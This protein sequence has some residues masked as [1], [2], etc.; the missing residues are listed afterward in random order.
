MATVPFT[1]TAV[2]GDYVPLSQDLTF[3]PGVSNQSVDVT[4]NAGP[5]SEADEFFAL[6]PVSSSLNAKI[7]DAFAAGNISAG[8]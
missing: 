8:A 2:D 1:A 4:V 5:A 6:Q 7:A 3:G